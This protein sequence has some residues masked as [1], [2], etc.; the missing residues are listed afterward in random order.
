MDVLTLG[1]A[2]IGPLVVCCFAAYLR[3]QLSDVAPAR[4]ASRIERGGSVAEYRGVPFHR[5]PSP[6]SGRPTPLA[7][8]RQLDLPRGPGVYVAATRETEGSE[9]HAAIRGQLLADRII[10]GRFDAGQEPRRG[11][12]G[13]LDVIVVG[14]NAIGVS[15]ALHLV[16]AGWRV[17][18]VDRDEGA[19]PSAE[20]RLQLSSR[21]RRGE[22]SARLALLTGHS[23]CAVAE[24]ADGM[25]EVQA[26][27]AAWYTANLILASTESFGA[28]QTR[29]TLAR[30]SDSPSRA[31]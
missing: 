28:P 4:V 16:H 31:A 15:A 1:L 12:K 21:A 3:W 10:N 27:R 17:L 7:S 8:S 5:L 29:D 9:R 19:A 18:V 6:G 11:R 24:R 23:V 13:A 22:R 25:L 30:H 20:R 14:A 26:E 2:V